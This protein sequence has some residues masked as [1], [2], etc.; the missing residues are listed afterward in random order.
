MKLL[1]LKLDDL[2]KIGRGKSKH[3]PRDDKSL[4]GGEFPFVQTGDV[5]AAN[6][7]L[8]EFTQT[9]NEKGLAQSKLWK[10]GTLLITIAANIGD[11]A[12]LGIDACFPD[13]IV[14]FQSYENVS[15]IKYV[16][17]YLD[18]IKLELKAISAGTTQDN[19]SLE[20]LLSRNLYVHEYPNQ[21]K[22]ANILSSYDELI[23]NNKQ[24]IKLLET[25]VDEIYKEW[26]VRLRFPDYENTKIV[27]GL[28]EG[29][30]FVKINEVVINHDNKRKPLSSMV[31]DQIKGDYPYFG[32]AKIIDKINDFIFDGKYLLFAEDGSVITNEGFPVLQFVNEKFWVSNHAHVLEG[33]YP[34]STEY[35]Y[36]SLSKYSVNG[37]ITGAAQP[38]INQENLNRILILK[39]S[40]FY[41]NSFNEIIIPYFDE[42]QLLIQKNH[43][44]QETRDLLLPRLIS[45]KLSV[46]HLL[47]EKEDLLMVA[48]PREEYQ[49]N[50]L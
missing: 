33:R 18:Y 2:G 49:K 6:F 10:K 37:L 45:G 14:G 27:D 1:K 17:Y 23:E 7:Y 42:I 21:V 12:I 47:D 40:E 15:D 19:M 43:L 30:N 22:I 35:I 44:L 3:R 29:W 24:R 5:K 11:T 9:Y 20:K 16:K 39:P 25:M 41:C 36:L 28:P 50:K 13:S 38:K 46:E 26:F 32:A 34:I 8:T 48:E 31:R 4:Y